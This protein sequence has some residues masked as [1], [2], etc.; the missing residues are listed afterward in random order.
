MQVQNDLGKLVLRFA[1]GGLMLFHGIHKIVHGIDS[2]VDMTEAAG[3]PGFVAYGVYVGEVVVP[4]LLIVGLL[5]RLSAI[6]MIL[7]MVS[8]IFVAHSGQLFE[9]M[10]NSGA[11]AIEPAAFFLLA[12][13]AI[14]LLGP[15]R[16]AVDQLFVSRD[17]EHERLAASDDQLI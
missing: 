6:V 16:I 15:G 9:T 10:A 5:T 13:A 11:W 12:S 1:V 3:V 4:C 17:T 8:A 2:L 14:L 7:T